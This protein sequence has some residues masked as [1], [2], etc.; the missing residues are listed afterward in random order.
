MTDH[1][2]TRWALAGD[3]TSGYGRCF[4]RLVADGTDVDGEARLADTL[5]ARGGRVLDLGS[6]MG[7]VAAALAARGHEVVA[8]E[9]DARLREQSQATYPDLAVLPHEALA[10]DPESL[11]TFDLVVAVGNVMVYLG[12]GTERGVLSRVRSLLSPGGRVLVGFHP[13]SGPGGARDYAPHE[14][15]ED[16][17]ASGLR[18]DHRF[19]TYELHPP[20]EDYCVFVLSAAD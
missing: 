7:R 17:V 1:P 8:T 4:G 10:L 6:G 18:V 2:P 14:L 13:H 20:A 11:G 9:P 15:V 16:A 12:E 19:G 5:L 3:G